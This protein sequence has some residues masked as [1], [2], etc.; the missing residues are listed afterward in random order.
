MQ[1]K[2]ATRN[3]EFHVQ[4]SFLCN[5]SYASSMKDLSRDAYSDGVIFRTHRQRTQNY[6]KTL[7]SEVVRLRESESNLLQDKDKL[8]QV[9]TGKVMSSRIG[10]TGDIAS[11]F[12]QRLFDLEFHSSTL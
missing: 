1:S 7:E 6:I 12:T 11:G 4:L 9:S 5:S 2:C 8:Q 3:G 10:L